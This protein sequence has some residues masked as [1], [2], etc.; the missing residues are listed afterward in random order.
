MGRPRKRALF[1]VALSID[2]AADAL[3][4]PRRVIAD[5]DQSRRASR[6]R[7]TRQTNSDHG[8]GPNGMGADV[9]ASNTTE[10]VM[11]MSPELIKKLQAAGMKLSAIQTDAADAFE[12]AEFIEAT[13]PKWV[14]E[15]K[16]MRPHCFIGAGQVDLESAAFGDGNMTARARLIKQVGQAD[17]EA[18]AKELGLKGITDFK[19]R[20]ERPGGKENQAKP[21]GDNPWSAEGW[22][23]TKQGQVVRADF[24]L[25]TRLAKAAGSFIGA[26]RP[27]AA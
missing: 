25:A 13:L 5:G 19:T 20:G 4:I 6:L 8:R 17:A 7:G 18:R 15:Q 2:S 3:A 11:N 12:R 23:V 1:P 10:S 26:T 16:E 21:R 9:A 27:R 14:A 22:N 24:A